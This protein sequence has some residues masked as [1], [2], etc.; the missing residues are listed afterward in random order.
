MHVSLSVL[1]RWKN[2]WH[3]DETGGNPGFLHPSSVL[4]LN[5]CDGLGT[6]GSGLQRSVRC[7][8][9]FHKTSDQQDARGR[10]EFSFVRP[11][12]PRHVLPQDLVHYF[13]KTE[14]KGDGAILIFLPGADGE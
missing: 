11:F 6:G 8:L 9:A 12:S 13:H 3:T 1:F 10:S 7:V 4:L 14:P 5:A 2:A